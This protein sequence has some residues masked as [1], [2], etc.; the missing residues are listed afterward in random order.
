MICEPSIVRAPITSS[1]IAM[2]YLFAVEHPRSRSG[3]SRQSASALDD[4]NV[5]RLLA[6]RRN[7]E[8]SRKTGFG[9]RANFNRLRSRPP[10]QK[11]APQVIA[12]L[13]P[14]ARPKRC[15]GRQRR[16]PCA[17]VRSGA[18]RDSVR[19]RTAVRLDQRSHTLAWGVEAADDAGGGSLRTRPLS[20]AARATEDRCF[21][22][23]APGD[24]TRAGST[25]GPARHPRPCPSAAS[26]AAP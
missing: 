13:A 25:A 4:I 3:F 6:K 21:L 20:I 24:A 23:P 1:V 5:A 11:R 14:L 19:S 22:H 10:S 15:I 16:R 2:G 9:D 7:C 12:I 26:A 17:G 18:R 8:A